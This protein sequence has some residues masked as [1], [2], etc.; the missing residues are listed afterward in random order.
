L[1]TEPPTY[2]PEESTQLKVD[3]K[4]GTYDLYRPVGNH[5]GRGMDDAITVREG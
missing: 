4:P 3:L 2:P 5:T 1:K